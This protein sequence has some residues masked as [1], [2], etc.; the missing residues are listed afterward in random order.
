MQAI[1]MMTRLSYVLNQNYILL[2]LSMS[3]T[4]FCML[5]HIIFCSCRAYSVYI[6]Q[7][8]YESNDLPIEM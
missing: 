8:P 5:V 3:M 7:S 2:Y 4:K 6:D 1:F